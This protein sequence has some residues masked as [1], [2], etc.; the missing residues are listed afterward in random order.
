MVTHL[1]NRFDSRKR[2]SVEEKEDEETDGIVAELV[3]EM[4]E[5][6][7]EQVCHTLMIHLAF[8]SFV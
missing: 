2:V 7:V 6:V 3:R 8:V 1:G 4:M 5:K